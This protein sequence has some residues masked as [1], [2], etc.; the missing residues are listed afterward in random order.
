ML[1]KETEEASPEEQ[2]RKLTVS[3]ML[4]DL[5]LA[6]FNTADY[7]GLIRGWFGSINS[8]FWYVSRL[9]FFRM[10]PRW[11]WYIFYFYLVMVPH[12]VFGI[13][14]YKIFYDTFIGEPRQKALEAKKAKEREIQAIKDFDRLYESGGKSCPVLR[15]AR[16]QSR[17]YAAL[18]MDQCPIA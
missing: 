7:F 12:I 3:Q 6:V 13:M 15:A 9:S 10:L 8:C 2:P 18:I 4:R 17:E 1:E 11:I 16:S 14:L 5:A